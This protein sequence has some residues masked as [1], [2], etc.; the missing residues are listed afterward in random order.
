LQTAISSES[1]L[2][3]YSPRYYVIHDSAAALSGVFIYVDGSPVAL[4][5][6][7]W[8]VAGTNYSAGNPDFVKLKLN[9]EKFKTSFSH[10]NPFDEA[11]SAYD[12]KKLAVGAVDFARKSSGKNRTD[13]W[14]QVVA[15][16]PAGG[17]V[18]I[19]GTFPVGISG[20]V[21]GLVRDPAGTVVDPLVEGAQSGT[22]TGCSASVVSG[23][24]VPAI[25]HAGT[26]TV[27]KSVASGTGL[28]IGTRSATAT[29]AIGTS[30]VTENSIACIAGYVEGPALT[31]IADVCGGTI[32]DANAHSTATLQTVTQNWARSA[33]A[34]TCTWDCNSGYG[35]DSASSMC[36]ASVNGAC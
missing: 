12:T 30:S 32:S 1:A 8:N 22:P 21:A 23:Y 20:S 5:G 17:S 26:A 4:T 14:F 33:T 19:S 9:P 6:G 27:T 10:G 28:T 31:C 2:T 34:G 15:I 11:F 36:K 29:C 16:P 35:W 18:S 24:S 7:D 3:N 13:S 25:P